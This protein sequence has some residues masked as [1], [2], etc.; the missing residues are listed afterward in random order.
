M[1]I[2]EFITEKIKYFLIK[3]RNF[4]FTFVEIENFDFIGSHIDI[5][6]F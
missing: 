5:N 3:F 1:Y 4:Q 2:S 6:F